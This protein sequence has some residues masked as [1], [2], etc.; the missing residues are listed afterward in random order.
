MLRSCFV[1]GISAF[2]KEAPQRIPGPLQCEDI[3]RIRQSATPKWAII[4][5]GPCWCPDLGLSCL[6]NCEKSLMFIGY[7][8]CGMLLQQ[9]EGTKTPPLSH[10]LPLL[11]D[12]KSLTWSGL[13]CPLQPQFLPSFPW[14]T[15]LSLH[16]THQIFS[17]LSIL[18][19]FLPQEDFVPVSPSHLGL[20]AKRAQ[21]RPVLTTQ[22][23][24]LS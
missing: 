15:S 19:G 7:L 4:T 23:K 3:A 21:G 22:S 24:A 16:Q 11:L 20:N 12:Y 8:V 17:F 13:C 18:Q 1:N 10:H 9:P 5:I 2:V 14:Y 6:Q